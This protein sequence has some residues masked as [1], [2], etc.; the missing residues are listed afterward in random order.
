[1]IPGV[2]EGHSSRPLPEVRRPRAGGPLGAPLHLGLRGDS[3]QELSVSLPRQQPLS[4]LPVS[5][6][7]LRGGGW[8]D[9]VSGGNA[10][11]AS[12]CCKSLRTPGKGGE[13]SGGA[14]RWRSRWP[15]PPPAPSPWCLPSGDHSGFGNP[16]PAP[17]NSQGPRPP[18]PKPPFSLTLPARAPAAGVGGSAAAGGKEGRARPGREPAR[19]RVC[20]CP[21]GAWG[22]RGAPHCPTCPPGIWFPPQPSRPLAPTFGGCLYPCPITPITPPRLS[23]PT[24]PAN[25][26]PL[27][28]QTGTWRGSAASCSPLAPPSPLRPSAI[29]NPDQRVSRVTPPG[30]TGTPGV[31]SRGNR[32][33]QDLDTAG[34]GGVPESSRPDS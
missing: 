26:P 23:N 19:A 20:A 24:P 10:E 4:A 30:G 11:A 25:N 5:S 27:Q 34:E 33:G 6:G 9:P 17:R 8:P 7:G 29:N 15:G 28:S 22:P 21:E 14:G 1:M 3:C 2:P 31:S 13:T 12:G 16:S 32:G 18:P